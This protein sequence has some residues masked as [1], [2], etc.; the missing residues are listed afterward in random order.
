MYDRASKRCGIID[1]AKILLRFIYYTER[2]AAQ[3]LS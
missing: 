3:C 1:Y 2:H